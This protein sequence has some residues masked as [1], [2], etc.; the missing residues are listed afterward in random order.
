MKDNTSVFARFDKA[1]LKALTD[2]IKGFYEGTLD[3][4]SG[5]VDGKL[6]V[7]A[8][9]CFVHKTIN[10]ALREYKRLV[11]EGYTLLENL[12]NAP[13]QYC[14]TYQLYMMKPAKEQAADLKPLF[15]KAEEEYRAGIAAYNNEVVERQVQLMVAQSEKR[16]GEKR[17]QEELEEE[18][19]IR[20]EVRALL[21]AP[22]A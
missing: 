7:G 3:G 21:G 20:E 13:S 1:E 14:H 12:T 2:N 18:A 9:V 10:E 17:A 19:R 5:G 8:I 22:V 15:A 4:E 11:D 16:R 6:K